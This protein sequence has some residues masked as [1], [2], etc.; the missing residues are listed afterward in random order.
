VVPGL[1]EAIVS[2]SFGRQAIHRMAKPDDITGSVLF[3]AADQAGWITGQT[4]M[5]NG[6]NSFGL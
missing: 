3:L 1:P 2:N 5:A 6:G 4:N